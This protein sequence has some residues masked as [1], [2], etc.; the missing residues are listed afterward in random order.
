MRGRNQASNQDINIKQ[1]NV[2]LSSMTYYYKSD[3]FSRKTPF[4]VNMSDTFQVKTAIF[5]NH[6]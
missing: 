1:L 4:S 3:T 6:E 5:D 2:L